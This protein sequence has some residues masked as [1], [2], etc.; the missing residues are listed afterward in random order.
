MVYLT[1]CPNVT[2]K[3]VAKSTSTDSPEFVEAT[4]S[5]LHNSCNEIASA[6]FQ[7]KGDN[8]LYLNN[9]QKTG[10]ARSWYPNEHVGTELFVAALQ[11][12][13]TKWKMD[14]RRIDGWLSNADAKNC[15][16]D[17]SIPFYYHLPMYI[18]EHLQRSYTFHLFCDKEHTQELQWEAY[19]DDIK[20]AAKALRTQFEGTGEDLYF[21]FRLYEVN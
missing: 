1:S 18:H 14:P 17:V 2:F 20:V 13:I 15:A 6:L 8:V 21:S 9:I 7:S 12:M 19:G 3:V 4:F 5:F 11:E 10:I 16:W